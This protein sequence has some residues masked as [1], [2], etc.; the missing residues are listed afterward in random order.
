MFTRNRCL[1]NSQNVEQFVSHPTACWVLSKSSAIKHWNG[2]MSSY[3]HIIL[4]ESNPGDYVLVGHDAVATITDLI[5][6]LNWG[7]QRGQQFRTV[8]MQRPLLKRPNRR[9]ANYC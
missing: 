8:L 4:V 6:R 2:L 3:Y 7:N 1:S 5:P 9:I